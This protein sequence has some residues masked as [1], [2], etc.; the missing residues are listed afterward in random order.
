[1]L[2]LILSAHILHLSSFI[3]QSPHPFQSS[4]WLTHFSQLQIRPKILKDPTDLHLRADFG[5]SV[6]DFTGDYKILPEEYC[7]FMEMIQS[8]LNKL[9]ESI[10][11]VHLGFLAYSSTPRDY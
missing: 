2:S 6:H 11:T 7:C 4:P 5:I 9:S 1:M 3:I 10:A 8:F